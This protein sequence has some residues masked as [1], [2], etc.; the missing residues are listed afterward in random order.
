MYA[1]PPSGWQ[2]DCELAAKKNKR[3]VLA[4]LV[5]HWRLKIAKNIF[6]VFDC[7][8]IAGG[9]IKGEGAL[10]QISRVILTDFELI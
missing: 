1:Y 7:F 5:A 6:C 4:N 3:R 10:P 8:G 9:Y 2:V